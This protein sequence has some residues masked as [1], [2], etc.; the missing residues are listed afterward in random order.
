MIYYIVLCDSHEDTNALFEYFC[1]MV[2][3]EF[4]DDPDM[5]FTIEYSANR[6]QTTGNICYIFIDYHL[7]YLFKD[8]RN[9]E[10]MWCDDFFDEAWGMLEEVLYENSFG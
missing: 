9:V 7:E 8:R 3:E 1:C 4:K 6:I 10:I 5:D 2:Y